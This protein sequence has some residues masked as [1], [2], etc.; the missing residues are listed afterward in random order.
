MPIFQYIGV[1]GS[2]LIAL[3]FVTDATLEKRGPLWFS[4]NVTG[5]PKP[6]RPRSSNRVVNPAPAP[7]LSPHTVSTTASAAVVDVVR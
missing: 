6:W 2:A 4:T 5:L 7:S 3:L 1:V